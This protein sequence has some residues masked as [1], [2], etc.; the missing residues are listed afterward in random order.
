M[1]FAVSALYAAGGLYST[2]EDL[3]R[4]HEA[5]FTHQL[6][7]EAQLQKML[8][9]YT[10]NE[11][12][13]DWGYGFFMDDM[14][15]QPWAGNGG[16]FDGYGARIVRYLDNQITVVLLSNQD[17]EIFMIAEQIDKLFLQ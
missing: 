4:W 5:L 7:D 6:L 3:S 15:G 8:T 2:A 11:D 17:G 12:G 16:M 10:T 13:N 1:P 9:A 14:N